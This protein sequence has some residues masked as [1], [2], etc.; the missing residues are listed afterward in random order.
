MILLPIE[1]SLYKPTEVEKQC[2]YN[3]TG[4]TS[5]RINCK[6]SGNVITINS[7][8]QYA[9]TSAMSSSNRIVPPIITFSL[10]Y[11]WNPRS[12]STSNPFG[13]TIYSGA[14]VKLYAWN[15]TFAPS[16][17]GQSSASVSTGPVVKM[18]VAAVP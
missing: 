6:V 1:V 9:A 2:S 7:G 17:N 4:F 10:P 15:N 12:S 14:G 18:L 16:I 5:G 11:F 8:F 13:L 3:L